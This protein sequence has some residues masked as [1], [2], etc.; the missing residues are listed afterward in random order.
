MHITFVCGR[1]VSRPRKGEAMTIGK[2]RTVIGLMGALM[3]AAS[4]AACQG[5]TVSVQLQ[6]A[7]SASTLTQSA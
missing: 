4:L 7:S 6:L 3:F 5:P 1:S 2:I